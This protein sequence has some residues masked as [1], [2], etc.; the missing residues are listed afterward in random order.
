MSVS[1]PVPVAGTAILIIG[2]GGISS[3]NEVLAF[4][5]PSCFLVNSADVSSSADGLSATA[6]IRFL[7]VGRSANRKEYFDSKRRI[8][9]N[10]EV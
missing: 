9:N 5:I 2:D 3:T 4:A 1:V 8:Y 6:S 10:I 7:V